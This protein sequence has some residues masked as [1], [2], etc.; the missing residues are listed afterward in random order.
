MTDFTEKAREIA[1][2]I[3]PYTIETGSIERAIVAALKKAYNAG[4]RDVGTELA[5]CWPEDH[6]QI[7]AIVR[8]KKVP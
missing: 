1:S 5:S 2:M 6:V 3:G 8:A 4:A 7:A